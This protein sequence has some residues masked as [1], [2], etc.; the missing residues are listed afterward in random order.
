MA[1]KRK[2]CDG[3]TRFRE[4]TLGGKSDDRARSE[5]FIDPSPYLS[6]S[7]FGLNDT[8]KQRAAMSAKNPRVNTDIGPAARNRSAGRPSGDNPHARSARGPTNRRGAPPVYL[9]GD[10]E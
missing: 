2:Y 1:Y 3:L 8:T 5:M 6:L 10:Y 7:G 4:G 9:T